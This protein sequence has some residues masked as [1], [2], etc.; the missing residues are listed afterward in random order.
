MIMF[1]MIVLVLVPLVAVIEFFASRNTNLLSVASLGGL[2]AG[3]LAWNAYLY[4]PAF[5]VISI[6]L[7]LITVA[8]LVR[9]VLLG[10]EAIKRGALFAVTSAVLMLVLWQVVLVTIVNAPTVSDL[11]TLNPDGGAG[12]ALIVYHAGRTGFQEQLNEAFAE[13]LVSQDWQ[14][15]ITTV[16]AEA[17]TDISGY[18]LLVLGTPTYDWR[19]SRRIQTYL[20]ELGD[21]GGK[22][23]AIIVSAEGWTEV[24]LPTMERL[25]EEANGTLVESLSAWMLA[26]NEAI[27]DSGDI[28][29]VMRTRAAAIP[30]P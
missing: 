18:D 14:V 15:D 30:L 29:E 25:V 8:V 10:A 16:S 23:T 27:Y 22:R 6:V 3:L 17:P 12:K 24:S 19:P 7:G 9:L 21:L 11:R 13:G 28:E 20:Q 4:L 26:P 1:H 2:S 5:P